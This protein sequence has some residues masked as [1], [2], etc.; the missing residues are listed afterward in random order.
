M[1]AGKTVKGISKRLSTFLSWDKENIIG[2]KTECYEGQDCFVEIC[3]ICA[4]HKY[5]LLAD[6]KGAALNSV[7]AFTEGMSN[8]TKHQ[9]LAAFFLFLSC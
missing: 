2:H 5:C 1:E 6:L 8:I 7:K 3:K 9:V 4:K